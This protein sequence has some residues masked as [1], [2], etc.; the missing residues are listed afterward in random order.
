MFSWIFTRKAAYWE[1]KNAV[2][3]Y[4]MLL[5]HFEIRRSAFRVSLIRFSTLDEIIFTLVL[6]VKVLKSLILS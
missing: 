3:K 2:I 4:V 6:L 5:F 1:Y